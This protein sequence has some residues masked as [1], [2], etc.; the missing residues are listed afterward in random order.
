MSQMIMIFQLVMNLC[1]RCSVNC[2][3]QLNKKSWQKRMVIGVLTK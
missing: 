1:W 3:W 2:G